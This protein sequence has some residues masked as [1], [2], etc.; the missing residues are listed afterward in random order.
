MGNAGED[1]S[2]IAA[3]QVAGYVVIALQLVGAVVGLVRLFGPISI[4]RRR[5][6]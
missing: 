3:A 6:P 4:G 1:G 2:M 5:K